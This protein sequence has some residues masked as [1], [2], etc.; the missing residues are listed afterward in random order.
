M[1]NERVLVP[2]WEKGLLSW[3]VLLR[4]EAGMKQFCCGD[5]VP[6]CTATFHG[7]DEDEILGA[8]A[9]HARKDHGLTEVPASLVAQVR[10]K[11][12]DM[13]TA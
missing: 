9:A 2:F 11:I 10:S 7:S 6:G 8:V 3:S 5:V 4:Q 12:Q 13:K 1:Y